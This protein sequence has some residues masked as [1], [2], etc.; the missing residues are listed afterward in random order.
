MRLVAA[1]L[2]FLVWLPAVAVEPDRVPGERERTGSR[3]SRASSSGE[4]SRQPQ[5]R[6]RYV[7]PSRYKRAYAQPTR[8]RPIRP[9]KVVTTTLD[10]G[11]LP[12]ELLPPLLD[13]EL[14]APVLPSSPDFGAMLPVIEIEG[15]LPAW[16]TLPPWHRIAQASAGAALGFMALN[17]IP[18]HLD[19]SDTFLGANTQRFSAAHHGLEI[20]GYVLA[21]LALG[22]E[23]AS[24]EESDAWRRIALST[25]AAT[26]VTQLGLLA[27]TDAREGFTNQKSISRAHLAFSWLGVGALAAA[28]YTLTF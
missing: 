7:R 22:A 5:R 2:V 18:A 24:P 6:H 25:A 8:V 21:G 28:T 13:P 12:P 16:R 19:H 27:G 10:D 23:A 20:T 4:R 1:L 26:L 17:L 15:P 9:A 11:A 3:V 14:S